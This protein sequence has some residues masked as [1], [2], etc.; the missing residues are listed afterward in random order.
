MLH[1]GLLLTTDHRS[2]EQLLFPVTRMCENHSRNFRILNRLLCKLNVFLF[3]FFQG[4]SLHSEIAENN[5]RCSSITM[6]G[7]ERLE[8][9]QKRYIYVTALVSTLFP[10]KF[11]QFISF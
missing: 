6:K 9:L 8:I 5:L 3:L 2:D 1:A 4:L 11:T 10:S 7:I